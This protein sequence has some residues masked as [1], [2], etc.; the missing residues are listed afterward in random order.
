VWSAATVFVCALE[1]LGRAEASF[2]P[3]E[4]VE[5]APPGISA[6]ATGYALLAEQR[7]VII[8]S[9]AAFM[10]ARRAPERCNSVEALREIAGVLA[11]EE[12]HVRHGPDEESA[13]NAQLTALLAVGARQESALYHEV[14]K[15][16]LAVIAKSRRAARAP[17]SARDRQ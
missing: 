5:K 8:T 16:R 4:L 15:A 13:Y 9:T 1:L 12:W 2:P 14:L 7:I 6:L 3:V 17:M 10:Q 11:H